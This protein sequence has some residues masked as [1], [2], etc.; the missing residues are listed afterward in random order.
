MFCSSEKK[1]PVE[2]DIRI[3]TFL[4]VFQYK[5]VHRNILSCGALARGQ[6]CCNL[7]QGMDITFYEHILTISWNVLMLYVT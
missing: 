3:P 2:G 4:P 6:S 1:K 5:V 7:L